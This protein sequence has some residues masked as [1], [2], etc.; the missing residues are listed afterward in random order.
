VDRCRKKSITLIVNYTRQWD[1]SIASLERDLKNG[2][3]GSI[4]SVV[5]HYNKGIL[6]NGGHMIDLLMRL[7]GPME[8]VTTACAKHDFWDADPTVAALLTAMDGTIPVYLNPAHATDYAFFELELVCENGVIR[9]QS[10][11]LSWQVRE[12]A[13]SS[14][15]VGYRALARPTFAEGRYAESLALAV[16]QVYRHLE[17]RS[18]VNSS[19]EIA[20]K[21]QAFCIQIQQMALRQLRKVKRDQGNS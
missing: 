1:P 19:G 5:A 4:R 7:L 13:D 10:G 2:R 11:G 9:M 20:L 12:A 16:D 18:E 21:V 15:F 17:N 3:W 6:N 14:E 8:I